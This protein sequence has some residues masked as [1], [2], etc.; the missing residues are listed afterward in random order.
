MTAFDRATCQPRVAAEALSRTRA[1]VQSLQTV[2]TG[3]AEAADTPSTTGGGTGGNPRTGTGGATTA[4]LLADVQA[5]HSSTPPADVVRCLAAL[6]EAEAKEVAAQA[7]SLDLDADAAQLRYTRDAGSCEYVDATAEDG[8]EASIGDTALGRLLLEQQQSHLDRHLATESAR[9][10]RRAAQEQLTRAQEQLRDAVTDL[11]P[12]LD[13]AA[14]VRQV[15]QADIV[16]SGLQARVDALEEG[17]RICC[18]CV[19]G[20]LAELSRPSTG[21]CLLQLT[22][23]RFRAHKLK[24]T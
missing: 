1:T 23:A 20:V 6:A 15:L 13:C 8:D 17:G 12:P 4:R 2:F 7:R 9:A 11:V 5:I 21:S 22:L 14:L 16:A 3:V 19:D 18:A 10:R 24:D